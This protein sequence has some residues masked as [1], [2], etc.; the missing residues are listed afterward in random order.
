MQLIRRCERFAAGAGRAP[1]V[2]RAQVGRWENGGAEVSHELVR[3]Y[4]VVLDLPEGQLLRAIDFFGRSEQPL[5]VTPTLPSR[6]APDFDVTLDLIERAL[7]T[8]RMSGLDWD[9]LSGNLSRM[10]HALIRERDWEA[11]MRRCLLEM[12]VTVGLE[13]ALRDESVARLAGHPRSATIALGM[14]QGIMADTGSAVYSDAATLLQYSS[15]PGVVPFLVEHLASPTNSDSLRAAL[16]VLTMLVAG[17]RVAPAEAAV[18]AGRA[19]S[20][21]RDATLP[22]SVHRAAANLLRTLDPPNRSRLASVL[23]ADDRR[24]VAAIVREGRALGREAI[25]A[26]NR[27]VLASLVGSLGPVDRRDLVLQELLDTVLGTTEEWARSTALG[28]LMLS[29][30][31]RPVGIAYAAEL[32]RARASGDEV[33]VVECLSVLTWLVQPES[34]DDLTAL[35]LDPTSSAERSMLC[36]IGIGNCAEPASPQREA[37]E[38]ALEGYAHDLV[39]DPPTD[40][41]SL[42]QRLRGVIYALG[43]RGRFDAIERIAAELSP[44]RD[45]S[46]VCTA[47][48][49]WWLSLPDHVR[50]RPPR[51]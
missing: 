51:A 3:R 43:L 46:D 47:V 17:G 36:A 29:P 22:F 33:A 4:E 12:T 44:G 13:Y 49:E 48:L 5:R 25:L 15:H 11:L 32:A 24:H 37:R 14:A 26:V 31:G 27:R 7:S 23:T 41:E 35:A 21:V 28:V 19:L 20:V 45:G 10:P 6:A 34:L 9:R 50:P 38:L 1:A 40:R 2:H 8:A 42:R 30:Q 16:F 39:R 18:A